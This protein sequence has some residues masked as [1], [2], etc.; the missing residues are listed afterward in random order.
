MNYEE[1]MSNIEISVD[2]ARAEI[3]SHGLSFYAFQ[4]EYGEHSTY[5][6]KDVM[7]WMGY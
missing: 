3:E 1:A 6:S 5:Y 2:E 4:A 7:I